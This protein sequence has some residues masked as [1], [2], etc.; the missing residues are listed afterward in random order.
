MLAKSAGMNIE[1]DR[2][3]T[4]PG[5]RLSDAGMISLNRLKK[6]SCRYLLF[7]PLVEDTSRG[8]SNE[9][10][11]MFFYQ[12]ILSSGILP[13]TLFVENNGGDHPQAVF[14]KEFCWKLKL[15]HCI[16]DADLIRLGGGEFEGVHTR[17]SG[18]IMLAESFFDQFRQFLL[19]D[20]DKFIP[21]FCKAISEY[22]TPT[23]ST[24]FYPLEHAPDHKFRRIEIVIST[25]ACHE[26]TICS[27]LLKHLIGPHSPNASLTVSTITAGKHSTTHIANLEIWDSYCHYNRLTVSTL[28]SKFLLR[29]QHEYKFALQVLDADPSYYKCRRLG[30]LFPPPELRHFE[31]PVESGLLLISESLDS[32]L[33]ATMLL[34]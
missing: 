24:E 5:G 22:N 34:T 33:K 2:S 32:N 23:R 1:F 13:F 14:L 4:Y 20:P 29:S 16:V 26:D 17:S 18:A 30:V 7:E 12:T 28:A 10:D 21:G 9:D 25:E 3:Y 8:A 19:A 6:N 15:P 11:Y 27:L 31:F